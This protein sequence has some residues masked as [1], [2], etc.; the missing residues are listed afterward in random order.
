MKKLWFAFIFLL[1]T[2]PL[3]CQEN[4]NYAVKFRI[5][6][7]TLYGGIGVTP[8]YGNITANYEIMFN[9]QTDKT[10]RKRGLRTGGGI[11]QYYSDNSLNLIVC[12]SSVTGKTN[13]HFELGVGATYM[14]FLTRP[15]RYVVPAA[16]I[17]YRYQKPSGNF[18]FRTGV[19][20]P[21][22]LY[23]G[24]GYSFN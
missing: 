24:F 10:F 11:Y 4:Q 12:Y 17:G 8:L 21:D 5:N 16:N 23:V 7:S 18:M 20:F 3:F 9:E 13:N 15:L 14:H 22:L 19:G 6:S 2:V 1:F